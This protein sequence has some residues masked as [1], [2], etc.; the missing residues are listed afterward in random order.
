MAVG[1]Q[2]KISKHVGRGRRLHGSILKASNELGGDGSH[3]NSLS[4]RSGPVSLAIAELVFLLQKFYFD[5]VE[6]AVKFTLC[7]QI[8]KGVIVAA[9]VQNFAESG[10]QVVGTL[11][12]EPTGSISQPLQLVT[13]AQVSNRL[14]L[15]KLS[16]AAMLTD[17]CTR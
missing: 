13:A 4:P 17:V 5:A 10:E 6:L 8:R 9:V 12:H 3:G 14:N 11:D 2:E 15:I 1:S 16:L 7:R